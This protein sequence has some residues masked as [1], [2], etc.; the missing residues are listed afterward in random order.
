MVP[1]S[2]RYNAYT[3]PGVT[4]SSVNR[5]LMLEGEQLYIEKSQQGEGDAF[6][7]LYD[8]YMP[9]IYRFILLKVSD[10]DDAEDL[11]HE[12]FLKAWQNI[13]SYVPMG[14]PFSSWVY[15]IARNHVIDFY[16]TR[17][18]TINI[19]E[20]EEQLV[21]VPEVQAELLNIKLDVEQIQNVLPQLRQSHQDVLIMRFVEGLSHQEIAAALGKKEGAVRILQHRALQ[22]LKTL[23]AHHYG[24]TH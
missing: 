21:R 13:G 11:T 18:P 23:L 10:R 9:K 7:I 4:R 19:D 17:K 20:L 2:L 1:F 14:L 6:G 16:R 3:T 12:V 15:R 22:S 8:H 5:F 24:T